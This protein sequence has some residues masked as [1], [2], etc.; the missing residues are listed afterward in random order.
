MPLT[1]TFE[2]R[3]MMPCCGLQVK[4]SLPWTVPLFL[5]LGDRKSMP[6]HVPSANCTPPMY[7]TMPNKIKTEYSNQA[8]CTSSY[9]DIG[10]KKKRYSPISLPF[11]KTEV[12]SRSHCLSRQLG[13]SRLL[14]ERKEVEVITIILSI[15]TNRHHDN[16]KKRKDSTQG[17]LQLWKA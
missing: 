11:T 16:T 6:S 1:L 3:T 8:L 10:K 17:T 13:S 4:Y 9:F 7:L 15:L 5:P 12:P 14:H 2:G